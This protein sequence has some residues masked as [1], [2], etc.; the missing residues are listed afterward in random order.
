MVALH[1]GWRCCEYSAVSTQL[2]DPRTAVRRRRLF[3]AGAA[4]AA[5]TLWTALQSDDVPVVP[6]RPLAESVAKSDAERTTRGS[7]DRASRTTLPDTWPNAPTQDQ[8][9]AWRTA[10]PQGLAAWRPSTPPAPPPAPPASALAE[11]AQA[12]PQ[13]PAFPYT[14]IG[15]VDDGEPR[16]LLSGPLRSFGVKAA[17]VIDGQWRVD[18]VHAQGLT[19]T[20]LPG[21]IKTNIA[22]TAS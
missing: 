7:S 11:V 9:S 10:L 21:G 15:R 19:L 20:W 13:A 12:P 5:V 22:F 18:A 2:N 1:A 16:A 17:D 8:R 14:L 6:L 3:T 4:T